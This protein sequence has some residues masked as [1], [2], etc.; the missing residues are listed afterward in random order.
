[1][2]EAEKRKTPAG[3][4]YG[5][6]TQQQQFMQQTQVA[7]QPGVVVPEAQEPVQP[8]ISLLPPDVEEVLL[9]GSQR[10]QEPIMAGLQSV[11][12]ESLGATLDR[13]VLASGGAPDVVALAEEARL[14]GL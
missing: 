12:P 9:G 8:E 10:P 1:M 3:Q 14:M 6:Q 13:L 4:P 11:A 5:A 7:P 2:P